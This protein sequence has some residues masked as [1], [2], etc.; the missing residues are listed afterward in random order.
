MKRAGLALA[1]VVFSHSMT[2]SIA[3]AHPR[4]DAARAAFQEAEFEAAE[5][6]LRQ[7]LALGN[8]S[9][10]QYLEILVLRVLIARAQGDDDARDARLRELATL[11]P[12]Y[13]LPPEAPP[14]LRARFDEV[15]AS[16]DGQR[17]AA[18]LEL[19]READRFVGRLAFEDPANAVR[20]TL[21]VCR[22]GDEMFRSEGA[23]VFGL[24][25]S[26]RDVECVG[27][28][29]GEGGTMLVETES[30][31]DGSGEVPE[32]GATVLAASDDSVAIG[33]GVG[34]SVGLAVI[35]GVVATVLYFVLRPAPV[36][37]TIVVP[38]PTFTVPTMWT[39]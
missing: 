27:Q 19:R 13:A 12:D 7:A 32:G 36:Q 3:R 15:R 21:T 30:T 6:A 14:T 2:P 18:T 4:I 11:D 31:L 34:V 39:M 23:D 37:E 17:V 25:P 1:L 26:W 38:A 8:L 10:D 20:S 16:L 5:G 28:L 29:R 33:I 35:A 9:R 24:V 22:V